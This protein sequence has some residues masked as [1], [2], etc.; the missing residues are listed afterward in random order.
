MYEILLK[1]NLKMIKCW[2]TLI[3][4]LSVLNTIHYQETP[5]TYLR[6]KVL[7]AYE[8]HTYPYTCMYFY[9]SIAGD[10]D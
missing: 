8:F 6:V 7:C 3:L 4:F 9:E 1:V 5:H 2:H 10:S